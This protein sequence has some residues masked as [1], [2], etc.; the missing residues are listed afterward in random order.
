MGDSSGERG[1]SDSE[2]RRERLRSGVERIVK[3]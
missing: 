1:G 3:T 2:R